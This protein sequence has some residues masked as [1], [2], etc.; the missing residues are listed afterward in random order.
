MVIPGTSLNMSMGT[1]QASLGLNQLREVLDREQIRVD[2]LAEIGNEKLNQI[3]TTVFGLRY[4]LIKGI[5]K[6]ILGKAPAF[7]QPPPSGGSIGTRT[8]ESGSFFS[9]NIQDL[10][11]PGNQVHKAAFR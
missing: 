5:E 11:D 4:K 9:N 7:W 8:R 2:I 10:Q 1:F 6:L 3:S